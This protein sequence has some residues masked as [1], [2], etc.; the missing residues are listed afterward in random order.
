MKNGELLEVRVEFGSE[1][2]DR[3]SPKITSVTGQVETRVSLFKNIKWKLVYLCFFEVNWLWNSE[4]RLRE[5]K[6]WQD[7]GDGS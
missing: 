5:K 3:V 7:R 4:A 1:Q 2:C 6:L